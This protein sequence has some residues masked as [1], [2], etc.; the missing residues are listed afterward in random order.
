M[1]RWASVPRLPLH[2][3]EFQHHGKYRA[4]G[5]SRFLGLKSNC[6]AHAVPRQAVTPPRF[7]P[8]KILK[9]EH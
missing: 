7:L 1:F 4:D 5:R 9:A 3:G 2:S 6:G 8:G